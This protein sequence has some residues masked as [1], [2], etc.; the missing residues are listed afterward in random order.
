MI[1]L[2]GDLQWNGVDTE[3]SYTNIRLAAAKAARKAAAIERS[4]ARQKATAQQQ[5]QQQQQ[6]EQEQEQ[7]YVCVIAD[8]CSATSYV[9]YTLTKVLTHIHINTRAHAH[10]SHDMCRCTHARTKTVQSRHITS[11][12]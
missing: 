2:C 6:Q 5:Q 12:T 1:Y 3:T 4:L 7:E 11:S 8:N 10:I 9:H